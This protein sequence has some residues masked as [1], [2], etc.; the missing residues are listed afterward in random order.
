[1]SIGKKIIYYLTLYDGKTLGYIARSQVQRRGKCSGLQL[2]K[3][4]STNEGISPGL[5]IVSCLVKINEIM[6]L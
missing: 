5:K 3:A 2:F 1:M 4:V 6:F